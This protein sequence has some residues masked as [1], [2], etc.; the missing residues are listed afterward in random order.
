MFC[1]C[2]CGQETKI[3]RVTNK[4]RGWIKG[5]LLRNVYGHSAIKYLAHYQG[6]DKWIV[7]N[8]NKHLCQCGCG[9]YVE[10]KKHHFSQGIA[11]FI[12]GH[13]AR[14]EKIKNILRECNSMRCGELSPRWKEDRSSIR[15]RIRCK[16][17]F[18]KKQKRE[19]YLRDE[20][21]CQSCG[22]FCLLNV[23]VKDPCKANIDHIVSVKDGGTNNINNGQILCLICHK[24]KHSAKANR[25][26][27]GKPRTGNPEPS[28]Q[29]EKVQRL[30]E[31]SDTLNN[32]ISV[33][34]ERDDIVQSDRN[35]G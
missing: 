7:Q 6:R 23:G 28:S 10:V 8:Q 15:G 16:V 4:K 33:R 21:I 12:W 27:S 5:Q 18:T 9:G 1:A 32:Q 3:A 31:C 29:S 13:H 17:D 30:L 22:T 19:I 14:T 34:P 2:G 26:N 11:K 25:M 20:G 24:M 35:I